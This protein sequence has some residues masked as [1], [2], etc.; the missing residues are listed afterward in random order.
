MHILSGFIAVISGALA[1]TAKKEPGRHPHA[2]RIYLCALGGI[3]G[4]AS[5]MAA[6]RWREDA[7]RDRHRR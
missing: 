2:G 5:V 7:H 1:A 4:S 6:I 3:F